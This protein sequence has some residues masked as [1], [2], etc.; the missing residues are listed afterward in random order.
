MLLLQ[1]P[2]TT[3]KVSD[4]H[5]KIYCCYDVKIH[6]YVC[7][8]S[9][10][11]IYTQFET[12]NWGACNLMGHLVYQKVVYA[13]I[14]C[15]SGKYNAIDNYCWHMLVPLAHAISLSSPKSNI[16]KEDLYHCTNYLLHAFLITCQTLLLHK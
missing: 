14:N 8:H 4:Y 1:P 11:Y 5:G 13:C 3:M 15:T 10:I 16:Y 7:T 9:S 12:Y 2:H 6:S